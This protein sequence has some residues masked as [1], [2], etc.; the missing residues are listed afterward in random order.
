VAFSKKHLSATFTLG[1]GSFGKS[2]FNTVQV[3]G[4][5]I[6]ATIEKTAGV[7]MPSMQMTIFGLTLDL[8][9]Q[10]TTLGKQVMDQRDNNTVTLLASEDGGA[11]TVVF[12]G[13]IYQS[14]AQF[15]GPN[16]ILSVVSM[17]G[18]Y[19]AIAPVVPTSYKGTTDVAIVMS[20]I[21]SQS[22]LTFEN[23]N[24]NVKLS[25]PY[26]AGTALQQMQAAAAA[27][28]IHATIDLGCLAIW[29][30][31]GS[32]GGSPPLISAATGMVGYPSYTTQ[33]VSFRTLYNPAIGFGSTVKIQSIMTPACGTWPVLQMAHHL[34]SETP[35]GAWF[36]DVECSIFGGV[37]V[38]H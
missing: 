15:D 3:D 6:S 7:A 8:L 31:D 34:E 19:Q 14:F 18:G 36:T 27:A 29:P 13:S 12:T 32:R 16:A 35:G 4:L 22:G 25:N 11:S 1:K 37:Q 2:G 28:N 30:K 23:N 26:F 17:S 10:L 33:A 20:N 38:A 21:A 9:N 24:V 5:R